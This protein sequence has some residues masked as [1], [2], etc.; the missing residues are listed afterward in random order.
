MPRPHLGKRRHNMRSDHDHMDDV[1]SAEPQDHVD[2]VHRPDPE[3]ESGAQAQRAIPGSSDREAM[4]REFVPSEWIHAHGAWA[5]SRVRTGDS[6][7]E[8]TG[9]ARLLIAFLA[10]WAIA[11]AIV[12]SQMYAP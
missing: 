2:E 1:T 8:M 6:R 5:R 3:D 7:R 12:V 10:L 4:T 9:Q 11:F